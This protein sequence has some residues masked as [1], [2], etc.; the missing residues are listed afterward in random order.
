[1]KKIFLITMTFGLLLASCSKDFLDVNTDP[2]KTTS[3]EPKLLMS[4]AIINTA[5]NRGAEISK[6]SS[7]IVNHTKGADRQAAVYSDYIFSAGDFDNLWKYSMYTS[8]LKVAHDLITRSREK[9]APHYIAVGNI[10][11][12]IALIETTDLFGDMP[13]SEAFQGLSN[14]SPKFDSQES[15]YQ[16]ADAMLDEAIALLGAANGGFAL[17]GTYD[18][19]YAGSTAKWKKLAYGIKARNY[20]HLTKVNAGYYTKAKTAAMSSFGSAA[21]DAVIQ[22]IAGNYNNSAPWYQFN[23]NR[24]DI[25]VHSDFLAMMDTTDPRLAMMQDANGYP[26]DYYATMDGHVDILTYDELQFIL[27]ECEAATGGS[28]A[29]NL[30]AA[31]EAN[32]SRI[33]GSIDAALVTAA[34]TDVSLANIMKQK[35]IA[36][37]LSPEAWNDWRRTGLPVLTPN[38]GTQIPRSLMYA[39]VEVNANANTPTNTDVFRRVWWDK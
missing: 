28:P 13:Y 16:A 19:L 36:M 8:N 1:M 23:D 7:L 17:D 30:K 37:F 29:A 33:G 5:Y 12:A 2:S 34:T 26:G 20:L 25:I 32:M 10:L 21:D 14:I 31:V 35:Y 9:S 39:S 4:S 38:T 18:H 15:I 11:M 27:A 6:F 22:F 3:T 24:G